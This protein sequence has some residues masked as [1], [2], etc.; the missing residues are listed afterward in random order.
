MNEFREK[1][2]DMQKQ[3]N[4]FLPTSYQRT[5]ALRR[6]VGFYNHRKQT[7]RNV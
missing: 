7:E 3:K 5:P 1:L 6:K 2:I 4:T